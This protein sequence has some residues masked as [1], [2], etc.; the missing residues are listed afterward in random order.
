[1]PRSSISWERLSSTSKKFSKVS[2]SSDGGGRGMSIF[3]WSAKWCHEPE[4]PAFVSFRRRNTYLQCLGEPNL[5]TS[6]PVGTEE[7]FN[8]KNNAQ[9]GSQGIWHVYL[10]YVHWMK[11]LNT[12]RSYVKRAQQVRCAGPVRFSAFLRLTQQVRI[13]RISAEAAMSK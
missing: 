2:M 5:C 9:R 10:R 6:I 13:N 7:G 1:M 11:P 4:G 12:M 3:Y 8:E